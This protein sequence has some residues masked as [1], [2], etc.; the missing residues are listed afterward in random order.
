MCCDD[1]E[2][3][4]KEAIKATFAPPIA[5]TPHHAK[6]ALIKGYR[7]KTMKEGA[8]SL[9]RAPVLSERTAVTACH[10]SG[11]VSTGR[12]CVSP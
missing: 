7:K 4:A 1:C 8:H 3:D 2:E 12:Q 9:K 11:K 10:L 5:W 6:K